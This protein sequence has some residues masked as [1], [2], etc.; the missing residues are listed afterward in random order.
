MIGRT[1]T[2]LQGGGLKAQLLRGGAGSIGLK[3]ANVGLGLGLAVVLARTLGPKGYG[4]YAYVYALVSL[5]AIPAQFGLPALVVRETAKAETNEQW[6]LMRGL[7]RWA[8]FAVALLALLLALIGGGL[9][10][11]FADHFSTLQLVTFGWGLA[12]VPLIALGS[13][14]GAALRGLRK[15]VQGQ[16]PEQIIR[17]IL[18]TLF[19]AGVALFAGDRVSANQAMALHALAAAISFAVGAWLLRRQRPKPIQARPKA[20]YQSRRWLGSALPLALI[21]GMSLINTQTDVVMLGIFS[22]A[23]DVGVYRVAAQGATLVALGFTGIGMVTMPYFARFHVNGDM[24][25]FQKL[26][27]S[28]A[29]ASL[30]LALPVVI[31]FI[32]FGGTILSLVFG[33]KFAGGYLVLAILASA[34]LIHSGFGT[35]GP[36]LNMSGYERD[37]AKGI[38]IA[39]ACN[40]ALNAIMIPFYGMAGAAIATGITLL[41]WNVVL[42]LMVRRRLGVDSSALGIFHDW[43]PKTRFGPETA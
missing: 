9:A 24:V 5:L 6:G 3:I 28:G 22:S 12:L 35:I 8:G 2:L 38:A 17:P 15:V 43:H 26:A 29:R 39:A 10:W 7:W 18:L 13:L 23:K 11:A 20:D 42:W 4:T 40:I 33:A 32:L 14:R 41:V 34:Q 37:T 27:T 25:R 30:L 21:A 19:I 1:R 31:A 36:L 16:L